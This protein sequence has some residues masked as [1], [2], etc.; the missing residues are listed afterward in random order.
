[1]FVLRPQNANIGVECAGGFQL[2]FGLRDGLVGIDAGFI[3][4]LGQFQGL[5]ISHH[6]RI[7]QLFQSVLPAQLE[8]IDRQFRL[9]RQACILQVGGAGL[10]VG[11]VGAN[12]VADASPQIGR[13]GGIEGQRVFVESAGARPA[14][15]TGLALPSDAGAGGHRREILC[16]RLPHQGAGRH[17]V[18]ERSGDVLIG[19]VDLLF[20]RVQLGIAKN[21]PPL[22]VES[23]VLWLRDFPAIHFLKIVGSNFF[24]SSRRLHRGAIVFRADNAALQ[25]QEEDECAAEQRGRSAYFVRWLHHRLRLLAVA[26]STVEHRRPRPARRGGSTVSDLEFAC[27]VRACH[28]N[29]SICLCASSLP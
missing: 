6:G 13:P 8:V 5:F 1:M 20:K 7:Q 22:A 21:L 10:R 12:L 29:D 3:Q 28:P 15:T 16:A 9:R 27:R 11:D 2:S 23:A 17:E 25:E 18:S 14:R 19:Y 4:R 26:L 24:I